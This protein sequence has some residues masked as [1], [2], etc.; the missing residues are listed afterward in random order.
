MNNILKNPFNRSGLASL[1]DLQILEW[2]N[3]FKMLENDQ[4]IFFSKE[5][6]FRSPEYKWLRDPI[7]NWSRVWEY[8]YVYHHLKSLRKKFTD[9][10]MPHVVDFGS[11][12]TFFPF[13][14]ARLGYLVT[15]T[16]YDPI[17]E[18]DLTRAIRCV[19]QKPGKII[20]RLTDGKELPFSD[21]EVDLV[22]CISV[23]EHIP[24]FEII[25]SEI[26]R[27]LK[28][29]GYFILTIDLDLKGDSELNIE[30]Y[31]FLKLKLNQHFDYLYPEIT[32]HPADILYSDVGPYALRKPQ[33][34]KFAWAFFKQRIVK[35]LLG[36]KP[37]QILS[38]QLAVYGNVL[39]KRSL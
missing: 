5:A 7:H 36:R 29:G 34:L 10:E 17:C 31:K 1:S 19:T 26:V 11:G 8:P 12:V 15:C 3:T 6:E 23:L 27:I 22:Y 13:S 9:S 20:F 18:K 37:G 4:S 2:S 32:I 25:I 14:V 33:G 35:P 21:A 28:P 39:I 24:E 30:S 16:D 38:F